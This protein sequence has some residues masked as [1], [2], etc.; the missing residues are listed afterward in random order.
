MADLFYLYPLSK[1]IKYKLQYT[2]YKCTCQNRTEQSTWSY[3]SSGF[4]TNLFMFFSL[5]RILVIPLTWFGTW[6]PCQENDMLW[7]TWTL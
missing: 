7:K 6:I 4:W 1:L 2:T 3:R 5:Q